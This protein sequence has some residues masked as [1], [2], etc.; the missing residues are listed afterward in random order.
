[1]G[2][3][4]QGL[5]AVLRALAFPWSEMGAMEVFERRNYVI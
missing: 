1:M 4:T 5:A 2:Q 3:I